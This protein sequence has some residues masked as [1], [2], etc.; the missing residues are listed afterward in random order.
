MAQVPL[1]HAEVLGN[2]GYVYG[3]LGIVLRDIFHRFEHVAALVALGKRQLIGDAQAAF[4]LLLAVD[5]LDSGDK[6][7]ILKGLEQVVVRA[8]LERGAR[9]IKVAVRR[10]H[11]DVRAAAAAAQLLHHGNAVHFR[12]AHIGDYKIRA[13]L[14]G[15]GYALFAV[16]RLAHNDAA[17]RSPVHAEDYPAA[18]DR[19]VVND[20]NL[21]H[22]PFSPSSSSAASARRSFPPRARRLPRCR[23][24][25][26]NTGAL[27]CRRFSAPSARRAFRGRGC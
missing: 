1:A 13:V 6:L 22:C 15:G 9:I 12:H 20:Q 5:A 21:Q 8:E 11:D 7:L 10:E 3:A 17:H 14:L 27:S 26:R 18:H 25:R 23:I 24:P 19:L 16:R 2:L 4:L